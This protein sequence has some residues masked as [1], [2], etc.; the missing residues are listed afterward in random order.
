MAGDYR[1]IK[2]EMQRTCEGYRLWKRAMDGVICVAETYK[3]KRSIY[4]AVSN[5]LPSQVLMQED[6]K[7][8]HLLL[9]GVDQGEVIHKD[10]GVFYVNHRG[11]GVLF[12]KFA[13]PS[14]DCY[15]HCIFAAVDQKGTM[16]TIFR[17]AFSGEQKEEDSAE[18]EERE[19]KS[20]PWKEVFDRLY[21]KE[22][23]E[24][25]SEVIDETGA[26]WCRVSQSSPLPETLKPCSQLI[27]TYGHYIIGRKEE[28]VFV[29]IPGRFLQKEQP[30]R[31]EN[32]FTLWQPVR[33]G[34]KFFENLTELTGSLAE[35]IFGYWI[36]G[37]DWE[38]GDIFPL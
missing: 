31:E 37:I 20:S 16:E 22:F 12:K 5:L 9:L 25:F 2:I 8:Y 29:G 23:V 19:E 24:V 4:F 13:G 7:E 26:H 34:E 11:E 10:F 27:T 18:T 3:N 15:S 36:G 21:T 35:E 28:R 33:G 6:G 1:K 30:L 38:S 14:I 17:G 32:V